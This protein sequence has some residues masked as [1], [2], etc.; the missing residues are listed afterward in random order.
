MRDAAIVEHQL[1][2][3]NPEPNRHSHNF[4]EVKGGGRGFYGDI[5]RVHGEDWG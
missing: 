2:D 3:A 5:P 4:S 1:G